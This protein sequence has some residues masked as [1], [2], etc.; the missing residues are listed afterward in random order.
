MIREINVAE[1]RVSN[2]KAD[3]H[4]KMILKITKLVERKHVRMDVM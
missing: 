1:E 2:G 3:F 4:G